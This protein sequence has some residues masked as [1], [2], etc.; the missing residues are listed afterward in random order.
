MANAL[1]A[2]AIIKLKA[3]KTNELIQ[4]NAE[5]IERLLKHRNKLNAM[6]GSWCQYSTILNEINSIEKEIDRLTEFNE[7]LHKEVADLIGEQHNW[8]DRVA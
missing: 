2:I 7:G 3:S 4:Q 6:Y 1:E 5:Q 8:E